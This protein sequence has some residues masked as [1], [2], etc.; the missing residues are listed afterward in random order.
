MSKITIGDQHEI[1]RF[2][3]RLRPHNGLHRQESEGNIRI[4]L[5]AHLQKRFL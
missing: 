3:D 4:E 1:V 2:D 5:L